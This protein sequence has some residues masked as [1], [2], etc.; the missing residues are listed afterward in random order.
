MRRTAAHP[1]HEVGSSFSRPPIAIAAVNALRSA[2][3][4]AADFWLLDPVNLC[5]RVWGHPALLDVTPFVS[6][7]LKASH[8]LVIHRDEVATLFAY[9]LN[10]ELDH[11]PN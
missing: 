9:H 10:K 11:D 6:H 1:F 3:S 8:S 4:D 2:L 7:A 5:S